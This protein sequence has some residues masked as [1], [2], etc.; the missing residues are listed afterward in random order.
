MCL[1]P[2][3]ERF[4]LFAQV[5]LLHCV[6][7]DVLKAIHLKASSLFILL[8]KPSSCRNATFGPLDILGV[9]VGSL[10][11]SFPFLSVFIRMGW[12]LS[13]SPPKKATLKSSRSW[14]REVLMW[15]PQQRSVADITAVL[16]FPCR[17]STL[18]KRWP[19]VC[20][21]WGAKPG[22]WPDFVWQERAVKIGSC[23]QKTQVL[24]SEVFL[25]PC[26]SHPLIYLCSQERGTGP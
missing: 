25:P 10:H 21:Q 20:R 11:H 15:M 3:K 9:S 18:A 8:L 26:S 6:L 1:G 12:T 19:I 24:M 16:L 14:Y 22:Q 13:I 4:V 5:S 2:H 7:C 17:N 23:Q